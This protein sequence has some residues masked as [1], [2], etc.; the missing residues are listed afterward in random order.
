MSNIKRD[1]ETRFCE[2][3]KKV[4]PFY[5]NPHRKTKKCRECVTQY[6]RNYRA[7]NP[8][9]VRAASRLAHLNRRLKVLK[10]YGNKCNCCG[11]TE[12]KF[13]AIDH[14][15]NDGYLERRNRSPN[16]AA[17]IVAAGYPKTY[18]ILCHNCNG[19]KGFYGKCPH[20]Q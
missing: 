6:A 11:E 20:Q 15:N 2:W 13:L 1:L 9:K 3:C 14:I 17:R 16:L 8:E 10:H 4:M 7:A 5:G 18:Q 12:I 19:A